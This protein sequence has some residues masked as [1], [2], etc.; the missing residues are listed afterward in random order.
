MEIEIVGSERQSRRCIVTGDRAA[1]AA[2]GGPEQWARDEKN[3]L[4]TA[5]QSWNE[6]VGLAT[7]RRLETAPCERS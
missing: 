5:D 3:L 6:E 2:S 4:E 7:E 1:V